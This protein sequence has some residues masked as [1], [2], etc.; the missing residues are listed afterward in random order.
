MKMDLVEW[1]WMFVSCG[2]LYLLSLYVI[3]VRARG[4]SSLL[5][6]FTTP[7]M[8]FFS[9]H[10]SPSSG[11]QTVCCGWREVNGCKGELSEVKGGGVKQVNECWKNF[12]SHVMVSHTTCYG[13]NETNGM[14]EWNFSLRWWWRVCLRLTI[15]RK[16]HFLPYF[17]CSLCSFD[18]LFCCFI[19]FT[20]IHLFLSH[21]IF[22]WC[23]GWQ[24]LD[25]TQ[26]CLLR[27]L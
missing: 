15:Y 21:P 18:V 10:L 24:F 16:V 2:P 22:H 8:L 5:S 20:L 6:P 12:V 9:C 4:I 25:S 14:F 27:F 19:A 11:W 17:I 26:T 3:N 23:Y 7:T 1:K 13:W